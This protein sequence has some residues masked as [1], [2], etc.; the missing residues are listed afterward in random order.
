MPSNDP[1]SLNNAELAL[2]VA[3]VLSFNKFPT[4]ATRCRV[5]RRVQAD[6]DH[7]GETVK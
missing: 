6:C 7:G 1:G 2:A 3:Y 5:M 4:G